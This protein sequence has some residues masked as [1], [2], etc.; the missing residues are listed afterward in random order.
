MVDGAQYHLLS[1]RTLP[2]G[3]LSEGV[4]M[5]NKLIKLSGILL[6]ILFTLFLFSCKQQPTVYSRTWKFKNSAAGVDYIVITPSGSTDDTP[7]TLEY[8][9]Y[10]YVTWES[11]SDNKIKRGSYNSTAYWT[12]SY[13]DGVYKEEYDA[14]EE[15]VFYTRFKN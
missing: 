7:F 3:Y 8:G 1:I 9:D 6:V 12:N 4:F 5:K 11:T 13:V 2:T 14:L 15:I 10:H